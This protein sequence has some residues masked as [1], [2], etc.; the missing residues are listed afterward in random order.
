MDGNTSDE[1]QEKLFL[2]LRKYLR[3]VDASDAIPV[4]EELMSLGLDSSSALA[5]LIDLE[6]SFEVTFPDE[7]LNSDMLQTVGKL[8]TVLHILLNP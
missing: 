6:K 1:I 8:E 4:D 7:V 2:I 5:L 3:F